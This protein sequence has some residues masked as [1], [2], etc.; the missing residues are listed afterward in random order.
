MHTRIRGES[1]AQHTEY[2]PLGSVDSGPLDMSNSDMSNSNMTV[3]AYIPGTTH[4][5]V[6]DCKKKMVKCIGWSKV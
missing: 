6:S 2:V 4:T 1:R 3:A 5:A